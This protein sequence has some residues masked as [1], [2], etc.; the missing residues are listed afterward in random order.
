MDLISILRSGL[1]YYDY[2]IANGAV[3]SKTANGRIRVLE[4]SDT[5]VDFDTD[6][7]SLDVKDRYR[8]LLTLRAGLGRIES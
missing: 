4:L 7:S 2:V 3:Q 8:H 6:K 1:I 5:P